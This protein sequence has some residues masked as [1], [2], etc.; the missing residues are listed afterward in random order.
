MKKHPEIKW[1]KFIRKVIQKRIEE[2]KQIET[3]KE[4]LQC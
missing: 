2:L 3:E 1:S 4:F